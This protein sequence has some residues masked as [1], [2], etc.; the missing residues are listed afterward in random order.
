[1]TKVTYL[2]TV[3][4]GTNRKVKRFFNYPEA[5]A[6]RELMGG[7]LITSYTEDLSMT[8]LDRL[9]AE[10]EGREYIPPKPSKRARVSIKS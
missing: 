7:N 3:G 9:N 6:Y 10:M 4:K 1:M 8:A 5:K 2:W